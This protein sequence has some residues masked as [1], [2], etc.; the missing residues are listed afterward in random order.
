[1]CYRS[2]HSTLIIQNERQFVVYGSCHQILQMTTVD[3]D[4]VRVIGYP[5]SVIEA[6][7]VLFCK[8]L[9]DSTVMTT[10]WLCHIH[11][12]VC[13]GVVAY[14]TGSESSTAL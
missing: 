6:D 11:K 12:V 13:Q 2:S 3:D 10:I 1:M 5:P 14:A 8:V 9:N 7:H 4:N